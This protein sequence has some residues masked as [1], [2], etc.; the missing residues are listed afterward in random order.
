MPTVKHKNILR[1]N[2]VKQNNLKFL[3]KIY[4]NEINPIC[5][6][7]LTDMTLP[8]ADN[9]RLIFAPSFKRS[10]VAPVLSARSEPEKIN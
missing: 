8:N 4:S 7:L 5:Q 1:I 6:L 2:K 10:P 3:I 9:D